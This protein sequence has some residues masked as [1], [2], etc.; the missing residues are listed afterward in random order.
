VDRLGRK[1][2]LLIGST[3]MGLALALVG[4]SFHSSSLFTERDI[5]DVASLASRLQTPADAVSAR[6]HATFAQGTNGVLASLRAAGTDPKKQTAALVAGLN[7]MLRDEGFFV[8]DRFAAVELPAAVRALALEKPGGEAL[9]R[10]N[11]TLLEAAYAGALAPKAYHR[12]INAWEMLVG[13]L[14]Y[15]AS[16]AFSM[17]VVGWVVI[18]EIYPTRTRG[19]AMSVATAGVWG[20]CYLVSLT[21]PT[22]LARLGSAQTFWT[23]GA[24]CA[25]ALVFV[26]FFVPETKG[27]SLEEI[28]K[29]W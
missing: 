1:P 23:Y 17:G 7:Q 22:L 26:W 16:F 14:A 18:S 11:R 6:L 20:A 29:Q 3:C 15:V 9:A 24:M 21:F 27:K 12:G 8:A 10:L 25:V 5:Q 2:L 13:V 19:R 28:E 4:F